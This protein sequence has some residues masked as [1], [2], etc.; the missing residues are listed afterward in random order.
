MQTFMFLFSKCINYTILNV[1]LFFPYTKT[2]MFERKRKNSLYT[3]QWTV[4]HV[5]FGY[6][7]N[8]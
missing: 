3:R 7:E 5:C 6:D 8:F 1:A 2:R 4:V